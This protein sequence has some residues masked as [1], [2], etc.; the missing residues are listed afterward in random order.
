MRRRKADVLIEPNERPSKAG[1]R[2]P[3]RV[4]SNSQSA[5]QR[6]ERCSAPERCDRTAQLGNDSD[7]DGSP[8]ETHH[9]EIRTEEQ[10]QNYEPTIV[11][12]GGA[13]DHRPPDWS[14]RAQARCPIAVIGGRD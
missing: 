1:H 8:F 12:T 3:T 7:Q 5:T 9:D 4:W 11:G 10:V 14:R 2:Q 13:R 6:G